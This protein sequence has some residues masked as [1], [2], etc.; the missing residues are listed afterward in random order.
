VVRRAGRVLWQSVTTV[1]ERGEPVAGAAVGLGDP[2]RGGM[3]ALSVRQPWAWAILHAGKSPE[4]RTWPT[5]H[6]GLLAVHAPRT[7]DR[8]AVEDLRR[9][10]YPVPTQLPTGAVLG[11]VT[12]TGCVRDADSVWAE[13]GRW[14]WLLADPRP[15]SEPLCCRGRLGLFG[16]PAELSVPPAAPPA[17]GGPLPPQT[18]GRALPR[19][20]GPRPPLFDDEG[21]G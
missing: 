4:N 21:V 2:G 12:V 11:T 14:H 10:G 13:P 18:H 6:R 1:P 7:I 16:L 5:R 8:A 15:W 19:D 20:P 9:R 3:I 17:A